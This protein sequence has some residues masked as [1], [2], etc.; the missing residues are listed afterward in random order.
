MRG[1]GLVI[2]ERQRCLYWFTGYVPE[3]QH[4]Q[5]LMQISH[6]QI[7]VLTCVK[8]LV[9]KRFWLAHVQSQHCSQDVELLDLRNVASVSN[10][11]ID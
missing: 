1:S 9:P 3:L 8:H 10:L 2:D 6:T 4:Q 7:I 5:Q 11:S